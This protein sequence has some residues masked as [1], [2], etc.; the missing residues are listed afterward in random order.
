[1]SRRSY[2][3]KAK[4]N[5]SCDDYMDWVKRYKVSVLENG[6][7]GISNALFAAASATGGVVLA[8]GDLPIPTLLGIAGALAAAGG[9]I[10]FGR[11]SANRLSRAHLHYTLQKENEDKAISYIKALEMRDK[12]D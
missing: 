2:L 5:K 1:M 8:K 3:N 6:A 10:A 7:I 11:I 12:N 4:E 9:A